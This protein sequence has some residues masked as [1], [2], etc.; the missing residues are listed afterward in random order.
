MIYNFDTPINRYGTNSIKYDF[1]AERKKPEGLLPM[2][3]ADMDFPAQ[4]EVLED[5]QKAAWR[6]ASA[7]II[8]L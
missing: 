6:W 1:V 2:W 8:L 3:V 5:I 4:S 7:W